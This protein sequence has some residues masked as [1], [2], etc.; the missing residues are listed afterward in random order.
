MTQ[1]AFAVAVL[2]TAIK[3]GLDGIRSSLT[4]PNYPVE[5]FVVADVQTEIESSS[6]GN[7]LAELRQAFAGEAR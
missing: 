4:R 6:F 2:P 3:I 1:I 5:E 7:R